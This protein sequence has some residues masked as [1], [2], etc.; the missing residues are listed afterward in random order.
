MPVN[1]HKCNKAVAVNIPYLARHKCSCKYSYVYGGSLLNDAFSISTFDYVKDFRLCL[2]AMSTIKKKDINV[3]TQLISGT[4]EEPSPIVE[5]KPSPV[6]ETS[7]CSNKEA[8]CSR[9]LEIIS[10]KKQYKP[11]GDL[12]WR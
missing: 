12:M 3:Y 2:Y 7:R 9:L 5:E 6:V 4:I 8:L 11:Y 10:E 1:K